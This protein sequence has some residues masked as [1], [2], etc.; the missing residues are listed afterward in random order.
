MITRY[1]HTTPTGRI[2]RPHLMATIASILSSAQ[3]CRAEGRI[4]LARDY[5][6]FARKTRLLNRVAHRPEL[7]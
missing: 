2:D 5:A 3:H 4:A 6:A 1:I 7:P